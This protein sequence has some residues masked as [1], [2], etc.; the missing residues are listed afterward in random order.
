MVY[1][2]GQV[3]MNLNDCLWALMS[4]TFIF[5][6]LIVKKSASNKGLYLY[7]SNLTKG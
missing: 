4:L 2:P 6:S 3:W 7:L 1:S 5:R